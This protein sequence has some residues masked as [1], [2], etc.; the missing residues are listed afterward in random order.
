MYFL[1]VVDMNVRRELGTLFE[2]DTQVNGLLAE[3][4]VVMRA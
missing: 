3:S 4:I 1:K 2:D